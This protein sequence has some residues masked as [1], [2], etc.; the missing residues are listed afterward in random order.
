M[1]EAQGK[2]DET[3]AS[4]LAELLEA[5]ESELETARQ[6]LVEMPASA[7]SRARARSAA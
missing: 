3:A 5:V 1:I 6:K 2:R 4:E 7:W